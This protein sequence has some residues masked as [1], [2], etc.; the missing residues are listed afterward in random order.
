[1]KAAVLCLLTLAGL[2]PFTVAARP[3]SAV[4]TAPPV[5]GGT[6]KTV[7]AGHS[8]P[9]ALAPHPHSPNR[10]YGAPIPRPIVSK[11]ARRPRR[12]GNSPPK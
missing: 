3:D 5:P 1:M 8:K 10:V 9:S 12:A 7:P 11:H 4:C 2:A 6:T